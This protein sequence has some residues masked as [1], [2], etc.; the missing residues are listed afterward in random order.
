MSTRK[1][2]PLNWYYSIKTIEKD[3]DNIWRRKLTLKVR[4]WHSLIAWF[5][6]DVDLTK[7]T[8]LWKSAIFHSI[9]L[10]LDAEIDE[11][12][13]KMLSN[14]KDV[15]RGLSPDC[16]SLGALAE[17]CN[18]LRSRS[19]SRACSSI[20]KLALWALELARP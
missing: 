6:A 14:E 1:N 16:S 12:F 2:M 11:K 13:L 20:L 7:K 3:L 10:P 19:I 4:N 18:W 8:F 9:K 5:R 17:P 15:S